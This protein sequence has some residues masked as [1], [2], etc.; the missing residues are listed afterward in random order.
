[1]FCDFYYTTTPA[2]NQYPN[3]KKADALEKRLL[4]LC[5]TG[6]KKMTLNSPD[7]AAYEISFKIT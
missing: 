6:T 2:K 7:F 3:R 1:M 5:A 4:N